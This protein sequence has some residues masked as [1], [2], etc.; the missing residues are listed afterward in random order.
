MGRKLVLLF[1]MNFALFNLRAQNGSG[2]PTRLSLV[3]PVYSQYLHN[4]LLI[5]PAYAGTREALSFFASGRM[6]WWGI[7]GAPVSETVSLH[8]LLKNNK[9][10]LGASGQ[11]FRYGFSK[12][13]S[14]YTDYAYHIMLGKGRLSMG[15]RAG[16]DMSN[17]DYAGIILIDP[18]DPA[19]MSND[20][21]YI[22]P[23]VGSGIYYSSKRFFAGVAVPS[24]LSYLKSSSG[25]VT[26]DTFTDFD[27]LATAGALISFS[28]AF[29]FKPSVFIDYPLNS[30]GGMRLDVNGNFIFYDFLWLG[31]SWRTYEEVAVGILQLQITPQLM[32]G[33]SYDY[34]TG[35]L[36]TYS[37]GSHE[38]ILRYEF[39][40]KVSAANPRYF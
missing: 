26:F 37:K 39:G 23:N 32:L 6:Q 5:N 27:L 22:L 19:F 17:T 21:P 7:K 15:L 18:N 9:V 8:T 24:F 1:I 11:F 4:G 25:E 28:K 12:A 2:D 30:P 38:I 33:Y 20:K 40:Y 35:K 10:G 31:A 36:S 13:T 3:Y 34:P 16:F 29:R 14:V